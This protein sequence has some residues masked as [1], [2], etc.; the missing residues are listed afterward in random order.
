MDATLAYSG[1]ISRFRSQWTSIVE[2]LRSRAQTYADRN[3]YTFLPDGPAAESSLTFAEL[4]QRACAIGA[5]LQSAGASRQRV[6]LLFPPGLDYIA[7]FFGCLYAEA[8]AVPAYPPRQNRNLERLA[9]VIQDAQPVIVLTTQAILSQIE[10]WLTENAALNML[11]WLAVDSISDSWATQW[12]EPAVNGETL[13]FLQYTSGS[14]ASPKGVMITHG[15]LLHNEE[16]IQ[17]GFGQTEQ[18]IIV[19][20]LPLFHDMGLIGNV[21]QPLYVGAPCVLLSPMS[22]LQRPF[23][24][25]EAI[26]KYRATTSGGPNFAYDFCVRKISPAQ[27]EALDLSSWTVAFN[28]A[29]PVRPETLDRFCAAFEPCGFQRRAFFPC[30]GLAEAT[31][32]VSGGPRETAPEVGAFKRS[33]LEQKDVA[34]TNDQDGRRLVS[35]GTGSGEQQLRIVDPETL[36]ECGPDRVGEIWISSASVAQGYWNNP[37]ETRRIFQAS[38]ADTGDGPYLRTGD[39]GFIHSDQLFITGRLKD[40]IIIRGRNCYPEDIEHSVG[41]CDP[42]LRPGEGAVF[43]LDINGEERLIVV[44]EVSKDYR[45]NDPATAID[46]IRKVL[47]E[48][49]DLQLYAVALIKPGTILK[50]SSG[51]IRRQAMKNAFAKGKLD[52]VL[53]W[54]LA[55]SSIEPEAAIAVPAA[56]YEAI[57]EWIAVKLASMLGLNRSQID[58]GVSIAR[59]GLDS[60]AALELAHSIEQNFDASLPVVTFMQDVT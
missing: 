15:N 52:I 3:L 4:D 12:K 50:T 6:L 59:Y 39:L 35:C 22:F 41:V 34:A 7:A 20:W 10:R 53:S 43:S 38:L 48:E 21:L 23:R 13:A 42:S 47:A 51:K 16:M 19:G 36:L 9:A 18:S 58:A 14:T 11:Q 30:Y 29:E 28:G 44:H 56:G 57:K 1:D 40:L 49:H 31:L 5:R 46:N 24:W 45:A 27:R 17:R 33:S 55:E 60:L 2:L 54:E 26:S 25:L 8:V 37:G 32:F